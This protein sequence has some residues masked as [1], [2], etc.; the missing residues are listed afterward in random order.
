MDGGCQ[1][2]ARRS[3]WV[4]AVSG[5]ALLA[6]LVLA[7]RPSSGVPC[8][9]RVVFGVPCPGCGLTRSL[10][11]IWRADLVGAVRYHPLG[12]LAFAY[13]VMFVADS[14]WPARWRRSRE[15]L[16]R[17]CDAALSRRAV[18]TV[19]VALVAVW[20]LR[21]VLAAFGVALFEW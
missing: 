7:V 2:R 1:H 19:G 9:F 17:V 12:P 14:I 3:H 8:L 4:G 6:T 11:F 5:C 13:A 16:D 15:A 21:L 20:A 10:A 18:T